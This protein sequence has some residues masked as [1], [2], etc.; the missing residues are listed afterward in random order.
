MSSNDFFIVDDVTQ[1]CVRCF[2]PS[3]FLSKI[4][5]HLRPNSYVVKYHRD[6]DLGLYVLEILGS[7]IDGK[8][9][10]MPQGWRREYYLRN[11]IEFFL[12]AKYMNR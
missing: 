2:S 10:L 11:R 7:V 9:C 1:S 8:T 4:E 3:A 6:D 5:S 12:I